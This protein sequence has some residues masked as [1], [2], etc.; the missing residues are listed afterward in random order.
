[1]ICSW[2]APV[3][4][5]LRMS[6]TV[7]RKS[8]MRGRPDRSPG[9]M[10]ILESR[11]STTQSPA[12]FIIMH[13]YGTDGSARE[14]RANGTVLGRRGD[15]RGRKR[16]LDIFPYGHVLLAHGTGGDNFGCFQRGGGA[17]AAGNPELSCNART[18]RGGDCGLSGAGTAVGFET[19]A[20]FARGGPCQRAARRPADAVSNQRG[21]DP[22]AS[23][24]DGNVRA[25]LAS[26]IKP[27]Q[28]TRR[29][30]EQSVKRYGT[31]F[32]FKEEK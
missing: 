2:A 5:H 21:G 24:M 4:S 19:P 15:G 6:Q 16:V 28:G 7:I 25:L 32:Y 23:R 26:S 17:T 14:V 11:L 1:M 30:E 22:A 12:A 3:P 8:R 29:A 27:R 31:G 20:R 10:V 18:A 13:N 9:V